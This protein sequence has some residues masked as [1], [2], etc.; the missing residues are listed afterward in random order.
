V[1]AAPKDDNSFNPN[2][3]A[4]RVTVNGASFTRIAFTRLGDVAVVV[5][6][7]G[8]NLVIIK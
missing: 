6:D 7:A 5:D 1:Y 2:L 8:N 3:I 4:G